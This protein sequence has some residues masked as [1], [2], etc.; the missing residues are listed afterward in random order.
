MDAAGNAIQPWY[1]R[2]EN[3]SAALL[4]FH[5][6]AGTRAW[7]CHRERLMLLSPEPLRRPVTR[8]KTRFISTAAKT[9]HPGYTWWRV[10]VQSRKEEKSINKNYDDCSRAHAL[11]PIHLTFMKF[12][13]FSLS[14]CQLV[15]KAAEVTVLVCS[16]L[17]VCASVNAWIYQIICCWWRH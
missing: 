16:L 13:Y 7:L 8:R 6:S 4:K 5:R 11:D 9:F 14:P 17:L 15:M 1:L 12:Y 10:P 2:F 3:L